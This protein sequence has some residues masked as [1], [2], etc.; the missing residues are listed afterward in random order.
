MLV[1]GVAFDRRG[2]RLGRGGGYFDRF[3]ARVPGDA[4]KV[5]LAFDFQ[6]LREDLPEEKHDVPMCRVVTNKEVV[7]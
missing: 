7:G 6:L 3:L 4:W 1:P 5:G 2:R